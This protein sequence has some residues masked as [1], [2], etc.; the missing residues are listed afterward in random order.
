MEYSGYD[1]VTSESIEDASPLP[2][3]PSLPEVKKLSVCKDT[4][5]TI[6]HRA[7]RMGY[8]VSSKYSVRV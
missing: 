6:L 8:M 3:I 2:Y 4:G 5:E 1:F 7:A